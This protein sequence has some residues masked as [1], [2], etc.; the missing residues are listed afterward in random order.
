M[1]NTSL[2]IAAICLLALGCDQPTATAPAALIANNQFSSNQCSLIN[3]PSGDAFFSSGLEG[4]ASLDILST[5]F[6][7]S[8]ELTFTI[9]VAG[10]LGS[11]P[12]PSGSN[13]A[14][15]WTFPLDTDPS[16]SP[17]GFPFDPAAPIPPEF[18]A[19]AQWDGNSFSGVFLDRRPALT[20][21]QILLYN[22][23]V[24]VSGSRITLTVPAQLAALVRPL[25]GAR[26][27]LS[28]GWWNT[29]LLSQGTNAIHFAD[30]T[31]WQPWP[32]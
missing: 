12:D 2:A 4:P 27:K 13:G 22:I 32:K 3:D 28:S 8:H 26:W 16:T 21:G 23:P 1:R 30:G 5:S 31:D 10:P 6:C 29:G 14:L 9:D 7:I 15:F 18:I 24:T 17:P 20:G 25:P 11:L 19:Y